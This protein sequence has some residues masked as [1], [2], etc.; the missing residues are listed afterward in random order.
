MKLMISPKG[1]NEKV[2]SDEILESPVN[3]SLEYGGPVI[4]P[5]A[6]NGV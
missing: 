1:W 2:I 3:K 6:W 4:K 5:A